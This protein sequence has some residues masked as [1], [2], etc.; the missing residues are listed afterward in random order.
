[1]SDNELSGLQLLQALAQSGDKLD[2]LEVPIAGQNVK[3]YYR[4]LG[5]LAKSRC[6]S[7]ATEY[8][9]ETGAKGQPQVKVTFRLDKY[10]MAALQ[11]MLVNPPVPMTEALLEKL[12]ES[13]GAVFDSIIPDPESTAPKAETVKKGSATSRRAGAQ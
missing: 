10:K 5:W 6:I 9:A 7:Y 4:K 13:V 8:S 11:E 2:E 12:D 1:M 3:F